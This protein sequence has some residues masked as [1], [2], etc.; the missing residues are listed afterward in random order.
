MFLVGSV[1]VWLHIFLCMRLAWQICYELEPGIGKSWKKHFGWIVTER[2][3]SCK[4]WTM[5][6]L[7]GCSIRD[8]QNV[9]VSLA[10]LFWAPVFICKLSSAMAFFFS[11]QISAYS[12]QTCWLLT[13]ARSIHLECSSSTICLL[14][15]SDFLKCLYLPPH[16]LNQRFFCNTIFQYVGHHTTILSF[17]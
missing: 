12:P 9:K 14:C 11:P 13:L 3:I 5:H 15:A 2:M 6:F 4:N 8:G 17:G 10:I 16:V 7:S 1:I